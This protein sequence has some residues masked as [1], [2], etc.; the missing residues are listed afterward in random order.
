MVAPAA[1]A[2]SSVRRC[3][4]VCV[5]GVVMVASWKW[6]RAFR[7][8]ARC[9]APAIIMLSAVRMQGARVLDAPHSNLLGSPGR[10]KSAKGFR[11]P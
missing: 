9:F 8:A 7:A 6:H 3:R 2:A 1:N 11:E 5:P 10:Q 4:R